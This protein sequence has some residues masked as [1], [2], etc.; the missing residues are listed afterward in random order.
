MAKYALCCGC[1]LDEN[2]LPKFC[3]E[4]G[5]PLAA[6]ISD[7]PP[8][9]NGIDAGGADT[10]KS[11]EV[12]FPGS[13]PPAFRGG[14][15]GFPGMMGMP[16]MMSSTQDSWRFEYSTS[17]MMFR[18]GVTYRAW[19]DGDKCYVQV[20]LSGMDQKEAP[21]FEV[22]QDFLTKVE[23]SLNL[24]NADEW[25]G[26]SGHAENVCDGDSFSFSFSDGKGRR[27]SANGYMAWPKNFGVASGMWQMWFYGLYDQ[28][29]PNYGKRLRDYISNDLSKQYGRAGQDNRFVYYRGTGE[30]SFRYSTC[31]LPDGLLAYETGMFTN[32]GAEY[33]K[34]HPSAEALVVRNQNVP[35]Q[36]SEY[37]DCN[38]NI[39]LGLYKSDAEG[40]RLLAETVLIGDLVTGD[41]GEAVPFVNTVDGHTVIGVY[42]KCRHYFQPI[43]KR[44]RVSAYEYSDGELK[45]IG[46]AN[47]TLR[48][49]ETQLPAEEIDAFCEVLRKL[50]LAKS[51]EKLREKSNE[52][53]L[54]DFTVTTLISFYWNS[55]LDEHFTE[56]LKITEAGKLVE[57]Y[58]IKVNVNPRTIIY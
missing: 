45:E 36:G 34:E 17:G 46:S 54:W 49:G 7:T 4:C 25:D 15:M 30:T 10:V 6:K 44:F 39:I 2:Y 58:E 43:W 18:S 40:T 23:E 1:K 19:Q 31:T 56:K 28:H 13:L 33:A 11:P 55:N 38:S 37:G 27:I 12:A 21:I 29:F 32:E 53:D 3:P 50:G 5:S 9:G 24:A 20:R 22:E 41:Y 57:G 48:S 42:S 51:E 26:F 8:E 16:G 52:F 47:M 35:C 14:M